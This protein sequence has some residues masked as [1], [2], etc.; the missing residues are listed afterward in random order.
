MAAA[1]LFHVLRV[2]VAFVQ[3]VRRAEAVILVFSDR[4]PERVRR[5][6]QRRDG[7]AVG[8]NVLKLGV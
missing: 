2:A 1:L 8:V 7:E 6:V 5:I 3:I 4:V